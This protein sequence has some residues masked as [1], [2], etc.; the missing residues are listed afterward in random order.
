MCETWRQ[1]TVKIGIRKWILVLHKLQSWLRIMQGVVLKDHKA[2]QCDNCEMCVH[3]GSMKLCKIQTEPRFAQNVNFF[4]FS[5]SFLDDQF[6]LENQNR[7]DPLTKEKKTRSSSFGTSK[8]N[9]IGGLKFVSIN[10]NSI[11]GKKLELLAFL[12]FHQPHVVAIQEQKLTAPLQL[13][14]C[15]RNV[16]HTMYT[17]KTE[18]F[19]MS[20]WCYLFTR[21]FHICPTRNWKTTRSQFALKCLQTTLHIMWQIGIGNLVVLVKT[22]DCSK[23]SLTI[24][25][26]NIKVKKNSPRFMFRRFQL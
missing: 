20:V 9:F 24:S 16:A 4:N 17:G 7:F 25:G 22:F 26:V 15:S 8:N 10:I 5:D 19:M 6:N 18:T 1:W 21:I 23:I 13:R 12:V 14:N 3:N 2:V 11:R